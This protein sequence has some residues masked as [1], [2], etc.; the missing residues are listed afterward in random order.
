VACVLIAVPAAAQGAGDG[1]L[2]RAPLGTVALRA[3]F[4]HATANSDLFRFVTDELTVNRGD[5]SSASVVFDVAYKLNPRM[6]VLFSVG[7]SKSTNASEFRHWLDNND[8]PIEQTTEFQRVPLTASF[9]QYLFV[10]GRS[11][12][13][14]A[15]IPRRF[16][17]YVGGGGGVMWYHF[18]QQGDFV[19]FDTLK[20]F[21]D[22]FESDGWAPTFHGF[23]GIEISLA[24]RLAV[25]T[26]GRYQWAHAPL[27]RDFAGFD[28]I[29]LSGFSI[30]SGILV[31]Y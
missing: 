11:V 22:A 26:E 30:T 25:T 8:Q 15:W 10:P 5:F 7:T 27:S 4:D 3:G 13:H 31:R 12:G 17:P 19:D 16:A 24:S 20:V 21:T 1:F 6:D 18:G 23:G 2:F 14:Y 28:R 9:K 29:D